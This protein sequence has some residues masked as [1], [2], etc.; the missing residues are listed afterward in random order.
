MKNRKSFLAAHIVCVLLLLSVQAQAAGDAVRATLPNGLRVVIV[1]NVLAPVVTT[2]VNY[3]V[4]AVDAPDGFPGMAH[5]QEHMMFRGHPGLTSSQFSAISAALGG[6]ANAGTSQVTTGYHLTIPSDALGVA[7]RIESIRMRGVLD[8]Q[9]DWVKE[10]GAMEQEI[11]R[12]LS[13]PGYSFY[14]RLLQAVYP[15]TPYDHTAL[16]TRDSFRQTTGAT[17]R[18]F[19]RD[20]YAPNNAILVV[21]GDVD[22]GK[23]LAEVKR[24]FGPIPRRPL[25]PRRR[26]EVGPLKPARIAMETDLPYGRA[27]VAYRLP[28]YDSPDFAAGTILSDVLDSRRGDLYALVPQGKALSAGFGD[29]PLPKAAIGSAEASFPKGGDGEAL[30]GRLK[31]IVGG[32]AKTGVPAELVE[33]AK[34]HEIAQAGFMKNS[35]AG[36]AFEWSQALAVEGRRSP[37]DDIEAI[38]K[39]TVEDVNRVAA[40]YLVNETAVVALLT[41]R[42]SGKPVPSQG[43]G[44]TESFGGERTKNVKMPAWARRVV[45]SP[46][47]PA[48][49]LAPVDTTLP[50]GL[51]LIVQPETVSPTVTLVGTIRN[52]PDIQVPAGK[53]GVDRVLGGLFPYGTRSLDRLAFQKALDD[54]GA[55]ASAGTGFSL[56]VLSDRFERGVELLSENL[57]HPALPED[58]FAVVRTETADAVDG[59]IRSPATLSRRA[60]QSGLFPPTDPSLRQAT[61]ASVSSLSLGDIRSY[62][63]SA[64]RP[65]L[66]TIVVIGQVTAAQAR[67]VVEKYFGGWKAE[68][69]KPATDLPAVPRNPPSAATVPNDVRVQV[70]ATLAETVGITRFDPDY[71]PLQVGTHV[72]AG[73]FYATRLYRHLREEAGLV[74][75]VGARLNAGRTRSVFSVEFA[76]EPENVSKARALVARDLESMRSRPVTPDELRQAKSILLRRIP[77]SESSTDAIAGMLAHLSE[78]GLSLDEPVRAARRYLEITAQEVREAFFKWVRPGDFVQV[79]EGPPPR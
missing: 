57:L 41:P 33:A 17:L 13:D 29:D 21:T 44:G 2:Q 73:G 51:R 67:A 12:D 27:V 75:Y 55:D 72:L 64:F 68:G 52:N 70:D 4:G 56:H 8:R 31:E 78:T 18:K 58:A 10:R 60:L 7:L 30:V 39:V 28:G 54:I 46:R 45:E 6:D 59:E 3:L 22:P 65:D 35:V 20:W 61:K 71:Y 38:R 26:F 11:A 19:Y 24:L 16:G 14:I 25:P 5:A 53:E 15:G 66:A 9:E 23:T 79:T 34:R 50:N 36:L 74:Y 76:C 40:K 42:E 63:A 69:P 77:L 37:E 49:R 43:V 62:H 47:V 32:Y 48:S 1:P